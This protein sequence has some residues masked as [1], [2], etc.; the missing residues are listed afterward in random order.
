MD[1]AGITK[2]AIHENLVAWQ[3]TRYMSDVQHMGEVDSD[4]VFY[5]ISSGVKRRVTTRESRLRVHHVYHP[6]LLFG[7]S[8]GSGRSEYY[9]ANMV[10]L[11]VVDAT[12]H[13][14]E[15]DGVLE[16]PE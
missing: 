13:V 14:I 10:Q 16:P 11:G 2:G 15:G 6:Y 3:T 4:T 12:G 5:D 1:E 8:F 9:V 7:R